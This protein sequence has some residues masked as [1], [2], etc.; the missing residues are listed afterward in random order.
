MKEFAAMNEMGN[1]LFEV[2]SRRVDDMVAC[3]ESDRI[4]VAPSLGF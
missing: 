3:R 4:A 1:K 2:R